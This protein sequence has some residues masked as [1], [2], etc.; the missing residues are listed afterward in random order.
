MFF[1]KDE[2]TEPVKS[3]NAGT[4]DA[5]LPPAATAAT[6]PAVVLDADEAKKRAV[7]SKRMS[8]AFGDIV[9]L[10]SQSPGEQHYS[11]R[12]L[13][14]LVAP[15]IRCGQFALA[16]AQ[17]K[18]NGIVTPVAAVLW[19][20]VSADVDQRLTNQDTGP[21]RL[22]PPEWHSGDIP[23]IFY[24]IGDPNILGTLLDQLTKAAFKGR[25]PK[26]RVFGP[27]GKAKVGEVQIKI[28]AA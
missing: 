22:T 18:E 25:A 8:A 26:M 10:M 23:W 21:I 19:G 2:T 9:L 17:S 28:K 6:P 3:G 4:P 20:L 14:W 11:L 13:D 7:A 24:A 1:K 12:D 15:A 16:E 5:A 27:D